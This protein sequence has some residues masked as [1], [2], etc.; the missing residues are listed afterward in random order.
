MALTKGMGDGL[1]L[2]NF[3]GL[4]GGGAASVPNQDWTRVDVTDGTWTTNDPD[5]TVSNLTNDAGINKCTVSTDS[6]INIVD[7]CVF[8]KELKYEDGTSV[9][10]SDKTIDFQGYVHMPSVG[11]ATS[12]GGSTGGLNRP[13]VASKVYC[14][15]GLMSDPGNLPTPRDVLGVG[16]DTKTTN[17]RMYRTSCYNV[18][19]TAPNGAITVGNTSLTSITEAKVAAGNHSANRIHFQFTVDRED[20][21]AASGIRPADPHFT[22]WVFFRPRYDN[23]DTYGQPVSVNVANYM[24]RG[25]RSNLYVFVAVGRSGSSSNAQDLD[26]DCYYQVSFP[27][28]G[29]N[30]S[31]RTALPS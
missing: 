14:V 28:G 3:T 23:G 19:N 1:S 31:G 2:P 9:D 7:G 4:G 25:T 17:W 12:D 27:E 24:G 30:P 5:T 20:H 13:P 11:W 26:F 6:N 16:L 29:T 21:T 15:I 10:W 22:K 18:S 8:Y